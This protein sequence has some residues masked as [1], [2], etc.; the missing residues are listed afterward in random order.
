MAIEILD[1]E[2]TVYQIAVFWELSQELD[3]KTQEQLLQEAVLITIA[4]PLEQVPPQEL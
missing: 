3:L 4:A 2:P 1:I